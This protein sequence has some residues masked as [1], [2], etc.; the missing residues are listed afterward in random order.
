MA[1][2]HRKI[3]MHMDGLK[4]TMPEVVKM[5]LMEVVSVL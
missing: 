5:S 3:Y 2:N 1:V 4:I